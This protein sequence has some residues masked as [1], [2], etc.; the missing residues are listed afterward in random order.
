MGSW[1]ESCGISGLEV[2]EQQDCYIVLL[3]KAGTSSEGHGPAS[4]WEPYIPMLRGT[5]NDYGRYILN[6]DQDYLD[7]ATKIARLRNKEFEDLIKGEELDQSEFSDNDHGVMLVLGEIF[8]NFANLPVCDERSYLHNTVGVGTEKYLSE[9]SDKVNEFKTRAAEMAALMPNRVE[10]SDMYWYNV[11]SS[12][13][14]DALSKSLSAIY[15]DD[16]KAGTSLPYEEVIRRK[17][18]LGYGSMLLRT[19]FVPSIHCGPQHGGARAVNVMSQVIQ[20]ISDE[21]I[22]EWEAFEDE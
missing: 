11:E 22:K 6:D 1:S 14:R 15:K 7:L 18:N 12:L 10:F 5:Y 13:G 8:D 19:R 20:K 17:M 16:I 9:L 4:I 2:A 21:R 3:K